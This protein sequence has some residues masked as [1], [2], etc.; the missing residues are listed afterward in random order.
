[1]SNNQSIDQEQRRELKRQYRRNRNGNR[2]LWI[3]IIL[4]IIALFSVVMWVQY[5][6]YVNVMKYQGCTQV[7]TFESGSKVWSC[8]R[9]AR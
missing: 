8:P 4:L 1:M 9:D 3:T 7:N 5:D 6:R 2:G